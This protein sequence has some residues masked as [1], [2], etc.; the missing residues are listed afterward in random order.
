LISR[1]AIAINHLQDVVLT[2]TAMRNFPDRILFYL[3]AMGV[4][5]GSALAQTQMELNRPTVAQ[6]ECYV[7]TFAG[8]G[9]KAPDVQYTFNNGPVFTIPSWP[10]LDAAGTAT[11]CTDLSTPV[12]S[13]RF[14]GFR[15]DETSPWIPLSVDLN[16][17]PGRIKGILVSPDSV[18]KG[19]CYVIEVPLGPDV[20]L[21]VQYSLNGGPTQT[22][23][24]WP[25]FDN[26][27]AAYICTDALTSQGSYVFSAVRLAGSGDWVPISARIGVSATPGNPQVLAETPQTVIEKASAAHGSNLRTLQ[28]GGVIMNGRVLLYK[29]DGSSTTFDVGIYRKG[30]KFQRVIKQPSTNQYTGTDGSTTWDAVA[31]GSTVAIGQKLQLIEINTIRAVDRFLNYQDYGWT[32]IDLGTNGTERIIEA[33]HETGRR[34]SYFI[35]YATSLVTRVEIIVGYARDLAGQPIPNVDSFVYSDYRTVQGVSVPFR[36]VRYATGLKVE[37]YIFDSIRFVDS[38]PDAIFQVRPSIPEEFQ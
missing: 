18:S 31:L 17:T 38:L 27:G 22:I 19:S 30:D 15:Y 9:N 26:S 2:S 33:T 10:R 1:I 16:V 37:E 3:A 35:D 12:G 4:I 21:D 29:F 23:P 28:N 8:G 20:T 24:G 7:M 34:T 11:I 32:L 25:K 6:T 13:F 14:V 5:T 36:I